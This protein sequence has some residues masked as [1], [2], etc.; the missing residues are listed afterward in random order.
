[1]MKGAMTNKATDRQEPEVLHLSERDRAAFLEV[2]LHPPEPN[3]RLVP[4]FAEH[5]RGAG[6]ITAEKET[7]LG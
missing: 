4:G 5:R 6:E 7:D 3:E 2:L 1:M